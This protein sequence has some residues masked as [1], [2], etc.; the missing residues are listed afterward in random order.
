M[1]LKKKINFKKGFNKKQDLQVRKLRLLSSEIIV[2]IIRRTQQGKDINLKS[3][4]D[5]SP[6][7]KK[8]KSKK[9]GSSRPNLTVTQNMLNSISS[10]HIKN[11]LRLYFISQS[12]R[13][14]A[15]HNQVTNKRKFF[16]V[17]RKQSRYIKDKIY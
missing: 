12:E 1:S 5:Y 11:G 10:R 16:G 17:D 6:E 3:F 8:F 14:K 15:Y 7:Y 9:H 2:G 13:K 4:I